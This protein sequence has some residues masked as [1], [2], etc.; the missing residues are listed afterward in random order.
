MAIYN[1]GSVNIDRFYALPHFPQAGETLATTTY[2]EGLGGKGL[3]QSIAV[4]RAGSVV[5]H[6]GAIGAGDAW[7]REKIESF[8]VE[9][10]AIAAS[11]APTGHAVIFLDPAGENSIVIDAG[12]NVALAEDAVARALKQAESSDVL[13]L[14]NETNAQ[15]AAA[16]LARDKGM[17]VVY[18]AAPFDAGAVRAILPHITLLAVNAVEAAQLCAALETD[19][20]KIPVPELLVT[21]GAEGAL[22][23]SNETGA[24]I[25]VPAPKVTPVDTTA[26]G[27]TFLGYFV[28]SL[29]QGM[30]VRAALLRATQAAALKV[31]RRG[32]GDVIPTADEVAA[33][34]Q[35]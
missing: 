15:V 24:Q 25:A 27:D 10:S 7:L 21:K 20:D 6:I 30:E 5:H 2:T 14:Q 23:R 29:D 1:L 12:A 35:T 18:S 33:F 31:T 13:V 28:A 4:A 8:G 19:L 11:G 32:T 16:K 22:W 17:R 26:A 3:N 9:C 34:A